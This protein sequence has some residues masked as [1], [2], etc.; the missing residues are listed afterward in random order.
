MEQTI[1]IMLTGLLVGGLGSVLGI[2]G[3]V[4][5]IPLLTN[6]LGIPIKTAISASIVSVIGT[7]PAAGAVY[8]S[9]GFTHTRL[10]M[11]LEIA[12]TLGAL[13]G[14]ITAVLL[15]PNLLSG[16]FGLVLLFVAYSMGKR[17]TADSE[18]HPTGLLDAEF[19]DPKCGNTVEYGIQHLPQGLGASFLA[20]NVSGLLGIGGGVVKVPVMTLIMGMPMRA[21]VATSN[22]MI[23][24][25][26]ATSAVIYYQQGL[27]DLRVAV[28]TALGVLAGAQIGSRFAGKISSTGL[29][30]IFRWVLLFFAVQ[31]LVKAVTG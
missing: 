16:I 14:G 2:G 15:S 23:G 13:A 24:V 26:A 1:W 18:C 17:T 31:M 8:I 9:R 5:L 12:T 28:P 3:G 7:S 25:T 10:A 19:V 30:H 21:A 22:F 4:L 27:I 6:L 29:R 11:I 20:G